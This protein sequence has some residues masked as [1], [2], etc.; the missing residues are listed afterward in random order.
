MSFLF[1]D[2]G[3]V[4]TAK[5]SADAAIKADAE[6]GGYAYTFVRPGQLFGG[7]YDNNVYLGTLF[8]LD[9]DADER[10]V[11]RGRGGVTRHRGPQRGTLRSALAEVIAQ[12][13]ETG[14]AQNMDFTCVN[15]K[16]AEPTVPELRERLAALG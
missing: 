3:G 11:L 12:A 15:A 4:L 8:Q 6:K 7:P 9:K 10:D 2:S 16:G 1:F 5:A 13:L 14:S